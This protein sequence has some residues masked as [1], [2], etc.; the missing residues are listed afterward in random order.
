MILFASRPNQPIF[1]V[2]ASGG[3][4]KPATR[5]LSTQ[6]S[7]GLP[8]FLPDDR[9][10]LFASRGLPDRVGIWLATLDDN[11]PIRVVSGATQAIYWDGQLL[12]IRDDAL[13]AQPFDPKQNQL[14]GEARPIGEPN[15]GAQGAFGA[16]RS[17]VVVYTRGFTSDRQFL[18]VD[19]DGRELGNVG[20]PAPWGNFNLSPDGSH[21]VVSQGENT[22][23]YIWSIDL[24]RGVQTKLTSSPGVDGSP[25][26]SPDG[27]RIAFTRG[28]DDPTGV[29]GRSDAG[30]RWRGNSRVHR[31][32]M[33]RY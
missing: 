27:Q 2:L 31:W 32:S 18:W 14:T 19:R 4:A 3:V 24:T 22:Q 12:F 26:W 29:P 11:A 16:S 23:G 28:F 1:R 20:K 6:E 13:L 8:T 15:F 5:S 7:H 33:S 21:V 25:L 30:G 9:H 10:F 17:G